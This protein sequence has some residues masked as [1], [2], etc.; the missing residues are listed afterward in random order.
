MTTIWYNDISSLWKKPLDFFPVRR[1]DQSDT[2]F[3]NAL[4]RF[5]LYVSVILTAYTKRLVMLAYGGVVIVMVSFLFQNK[6]W[7]THQDRR[8]NPRDYC[9]LPTLENPY[10]NTLTDEF[11]KGGVAAV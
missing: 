7:N 5:V 4:V 9:R 10:A 6:V 3:V 2:E 1:R 8:N 11:G